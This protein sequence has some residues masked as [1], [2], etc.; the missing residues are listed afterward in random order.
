MTKGRDLNP[1][2]QKVDDQVLG[3]GGSEDTTRANEEVGKGTTGWVT[4]LLIPQV[5]GEVRDLGSRVTDGPGVPLLQHQMRGCGNGQY[6]DIHPSGQETWKI[7][8][9]TR[10]KKEEKFNKIQ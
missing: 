1:S 8:K 9:G 6:N 7:R 2:P 10:K 4:S 3:H 5:R